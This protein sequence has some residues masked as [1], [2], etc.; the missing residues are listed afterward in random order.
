M[1]SALVCFVEGLSDEIFLRNVIV[2]RINAR[3]YDITLVQYAEA[4]KEKTAEY[5][6]SLACAS[7]GKQWDYLMLADRNSE[8]C[9]SER[10]RLLQEH[11][12]LDDERR[13]IIATPEI[14]AWYIAGLTDAFKDAHGI[15]SPKVSCDSVTKEILCRAIPAKM[16]TP[17]ALCY[18]N[19]TK[20]YDLD[21]ARGNSASLRYFCQRLNI[22]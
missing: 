13:A 4:T 15:A 18:L 9:V 1:K 3:Y 10:R 17:K 6:R 2:P 11:F 22:K 5:C 14:E 8:A 16:R 20:S 7:R 21:L 12:S 19:L